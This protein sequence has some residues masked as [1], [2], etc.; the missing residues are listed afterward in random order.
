MQLKTISKIYFRFVKDNYSC[1]YSCAKDIQ[2]VLKQSL[3][4]LIWDL[5]LISISICCYC[6]LGLTICNYHDAT[7]WVL[8]YQPYKTFQRAKRFCQKI[9]YHLGILVKELMS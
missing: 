2:I 6:F 9:I 8:W 4:D 1:N 7:L 3:S 5:V